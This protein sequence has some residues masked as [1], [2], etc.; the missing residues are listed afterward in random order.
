[1]RYEIRFDTE[2]PA[3]TLRSILAQN[4]AIDPRRVFI[5]TL[6]DR[7]LDGPPP[8]VIVTPSAGQQGFG[9]RLMGDTALADATGLTELELA[10]LLS[11]RLGIPSLIDD[12]TDHPDRWILVTQG[13][14]HGPVITDEDLA[15]D[16]DLRI[17]HALQPIPGAPRLPVVPEHR[18]DAPPPI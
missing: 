10:H 1:M 17:V 7:P 3:D 5:G 15:E 4:F 13:G 2:V 11:Q 12:G 8:V 18:W 16:G 9:W 6:D 14:G